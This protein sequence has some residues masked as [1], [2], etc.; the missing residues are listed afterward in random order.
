MDPV[1]EQAARQMP[2]LM[3]EHGVEDYYVEFW[4]LWMQAL[5]YTQPHLLAYLIYMVE[6]LLQMKSVL[7]PHGS[8]YLH[9]DPTA[10]HYIKVMMDGIFGHR[11]FRN[12]IT[13]QRTESHNTA[14]KYGNIADTILF[15]SMSEKWT[16][17][18]QYE[19]YSDAQ[20]NR[21]RHNDDDGRH[22][23][24]ENLTAPRPDSDSGKF[25]WR[26]NKPGPTRGWGYKL[27]QLE[28]WWAQGRIKTKRDGTPRLDGLVVY[29]DEAE[30]KP[31]QNI[32]T[33]IP[34]IGN[35]SKERLGYQTQKPIRLLDRIIQA[36]SNE[37]D[38][39][40]D[41][42]CG[43]GTTIY[44]AEKLGRK[45]IG[46]DIAILAVRLVA[47]T[48]HSRYQLEDGRDYEITG[49]PVSE[50]Q[51]LDLFRR[52]P[53]QFEH[54]AV[55]RV[56]GFPNQKQVADKGID[57]RIY[58]ETLDG[59]RSMI[60]SVKGGHVAPTHIRDLVGVL[61]HDEAVM[62]GFISNREPTNG[63]RQAAAGAGMFEYGNESY[64]RVQFLTINDL[65]EGRELR[66]PTKV[67][68]KVK[69]AQAKFR[70]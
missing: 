30:G 37:G 57:G 5:R 47:D 61:G 35:T 18:P 53:F 10:S 66:T 16:W 20:L 34:R 38:M 36:S 13:W 44:A 19:A 9:C 68:A 24:L 12:E 7:K 29:L 58:F 32:W 46:C 40:F 65:F 31:L 21:Y 4:R 11:N 1:K 60:L 56:G 48:L 62:A 3:R 54:W 63:M 70:W 6:R 23:K 69:S 43:C 64:P 17:N 28:E 15:Y 2:V 22:Y 33:D 67:K 41:P 14:N 55:E 45:W 26:G 51:A 49:V 50:E 8:I 42:F 59:M 25:E 27:D 52:D 39:V